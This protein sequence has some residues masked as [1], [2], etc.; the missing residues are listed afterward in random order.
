MFAHKR[1]F[2]FW[3]IAAA[4]YLY[5]MHHDHHEHDRLVYPIYQSKQYVNVCRSGAS[6]SCGER[7][8]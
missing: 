6:L 4:F 2:V 5:L 8:N 7:A 1:Y 3:G